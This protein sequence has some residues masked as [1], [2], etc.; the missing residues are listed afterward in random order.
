MRPIRVILM[1]ALL[2]PNASI[3][4]VA[5]AGPSATP[6]NVKTIKAEQDSAFAKLVEQYGDSVLTEEGPGY[7][8][9]QLW[10]RQWMPLTWPTG[11]FPWNHYYGDSGPARND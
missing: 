3:S 2:G 8:L 1:L 4:L 10:L 6:W 11:V 7:G 5:Q 9:Y